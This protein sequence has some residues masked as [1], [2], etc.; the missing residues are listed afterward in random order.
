MHTFVGD[1]ASPLW[2]LY[3]SAGATDRGNEYRTYGAPLNGEHPAPR[4]RPM[5]GAN[6]QKF[7]L[8][9]T[10][11]KDGLDNSVTTT[12]TSHPT[13]GAYAVTGAFEKVWEANAG[14][15]GPA[16]SAAVTSNG[17]PVRQDFAG[18]YL[19]YDWM[20]EG[21]RVGGWFPCGWDLNSM[22]C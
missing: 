17:W 8:R 20:N 4:S 21:A 7:L 9:D 14:T 16:K 19:V 5:A 2:R 10:D 1:P 6:A 15:L 22:N 3:R 18:G 12:L 11:P 13:Y